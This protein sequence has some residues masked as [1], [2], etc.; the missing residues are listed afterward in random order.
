MQRRGHCRMPSPLGELV[1]Q[2]AEID[3]E[4]AQL[5]LEVFIGFASIQRQQNARGADRCHGQTPKKTWPRKSKAR[6]RGN[7][8]F[9]RPMAPRPVQHTRGSELEPCSSQL[10]TTVNAS[11]ESRLR[12]SSLH[13]G[14]RR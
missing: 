11:R 4:H 3:A 1:A 7:D 10:R 6:N 13:G 14:T 2:E 5:V 8:L 12:R 9:E